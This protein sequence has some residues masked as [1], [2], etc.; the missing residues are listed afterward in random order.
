MR[1]P[2]RFARAL[3]RVPTCTVSLLVGFSKLEDFAKSV[4]FSI[5][6]GISA[7]GL[8]KSGRFLE[9]ASPTQDSRHQRGSNIL[10]LLFEICPGFDS[11]PP[12]FSI[13][14][15]SLGSVDGMHHPGVKSLIFE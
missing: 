3:C 8:A 14:N 12:L 4:W 11:L 7:D 15:G 9:K 1:R 6:V 10:L 2:C 5:P 13:K